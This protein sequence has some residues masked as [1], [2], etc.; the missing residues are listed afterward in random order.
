MVEDD[1]VNL[2]LIVRILRELGYEPLTAPNGFE[3]VAIFEEENPDCIL[4]DVQMPEMD[5]LEA[6]RK[7]RN[8]ESSRQR[9]PVFISA[10]T[11]NIL[12]E[13]QQRCFDAGMNAYLNKPVKSQSIVNVLTEAFTGRS[14]SGG[15][16]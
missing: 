5:G 14:Q 6:T 2:K 15:V 3:A 12:P 1:K 4:M 10:L 9:R 16:E 8:L 13:D 7:I 11:A